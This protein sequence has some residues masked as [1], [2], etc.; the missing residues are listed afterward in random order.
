M[1]DNVIRYYSGASA[2]GE[3]IYAARLRGTV[4][5]ASYPDCPHNPVSLHG[6]AQLLTKQLVKAHILESIK[7]V[8]SEELYQACVHVA[9]G[10]KIHPKVKWNGMRGK[11]SDVSEFADAVKRRT[12]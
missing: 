9:D 6:V 1:N 7:D 11:F 5:C 2:D 4:V 10:V 3:I 12:K 8:P